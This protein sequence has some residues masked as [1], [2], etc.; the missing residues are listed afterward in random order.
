LK[1][2]EDNSTQR[3]ETVSGL[4]LNTGKWKG[5]INSGS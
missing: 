4:L 2:R 1:K 3:T 5:C